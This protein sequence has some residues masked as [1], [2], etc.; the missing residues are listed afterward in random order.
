M[1]DEVGIVN[2]EK[3]RRSMRPRGFFLRRSERLELGECFLDASKRFQYVF[4]AV[5]GGQPE[6]PF[7]ARS[8]ARAWSSNDVGFFKQR[9]EEIP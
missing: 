6:V 3:P 8:K 7:P 1:A 9:V 2:N 5:E 4:A